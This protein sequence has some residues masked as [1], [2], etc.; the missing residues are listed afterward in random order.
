M[1]AWR[2]KPRATYDRWKNR[3]GAVEFIS[4]R[5]REG[6]SFAQAFEEMKKVAREEGFIYWNGG[7][8][9]ISSATITRLR[10]DCIKQM[11][12]ASS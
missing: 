8:E 7:L 9:F 4:A 3:K 6:K 12:K 5:M 1:A 11:K 2:K 10:N